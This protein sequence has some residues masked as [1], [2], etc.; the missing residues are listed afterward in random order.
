MSDEVRQ[1]RIVCDATA[2]PRHRGRKKTLVIFN[3]SGEGWAIAYEAR[4][5]TATSMRSGHSHP[6]V[7]VMDG[8]R[9]AG[10]SHW[11]AMRFRS[12]MERHPEV[13]EG[14]ELPEWH[15]KVHPKCPWCGAEADLREERL[16]PIINALAAAGRGSMTLRD[17]QR[18][19]S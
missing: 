5:F 15:V 8:D 14:E 9:P 18:V 13:A 6:A 2:H 11:N 1:V 10:V 19:S 3:R 16:V 12:W 17:L 7:T 4:K